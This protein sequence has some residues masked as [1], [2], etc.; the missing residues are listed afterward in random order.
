MR[1]KRTDRTHA[2][3]RDRLRALG[4]TVYDC[5]R[6]GGG[7]P[8]LLLAHAGRSYWIEV[9]DGAKKPSA[10]KLTAAQEDFHRKWQGEPI[11]VLE[12]AEQA[13][14]WWREVVCQQLTV[15]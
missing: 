6:I 1:G 5:S 13:E 8:D 11:W 7:F 14:Q 4:A 9:K 2:P 10:R 12:S 15:Y 3:I